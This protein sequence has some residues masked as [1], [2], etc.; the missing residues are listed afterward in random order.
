MPKTLLCTSNII[1]MHARGKIKSFNVPTLELRVSLK[2]ALT[3]SPLCP[4]PS[5]SWHPTDEAC[6][7]HPPR[8]QHRISPRASTQLHPHPPRRKTSLGNATAL[9]LIQPTIEL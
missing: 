6:N 7:N 2:R 9:P 4:S 5:A 8:P 3:Y 1:I